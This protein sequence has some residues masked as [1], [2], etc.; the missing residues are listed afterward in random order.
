MVCDLF[1]LHGEPFVS[2]AIPNSA[3]VLAF[4]TLGLAGGGCVSF[5]L[6]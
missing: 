5:D 1:A 2:G 3:E 6:F 4:P